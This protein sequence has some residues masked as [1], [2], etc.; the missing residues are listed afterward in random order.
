MLR[1][2]NFF[3]FRDSLTGNLN[4]YILLSYFRI[5]AQMSK[6]GHVNGR[7]A[8][9]AFQGLLSLSNSEP[10]AGTLKVMPLLR[11]PIAYILIRPFLSDVDV[12]QMPGCVPS[13]LFQ[14]SQKWHSDI[15]DEM[16]SIPRLYP[17][18][19]VWWHPDLVHSI[20]NKVEG[21]EANS[22]MCI[23]AA[24]DCQMNRVYL[25]KLR[26][27]FILGKT[28]PDFPESDSEIKF[29]DKANISDLTAVGRKSMGWEI[30][31]ELVTKQFNEK[32]E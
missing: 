32:C 24:P 11:E 26:H 13:K 14:I 6:T 5:E 23:S 8:F 28:P 9:R 7:S 20:E 12:N 15:Y 10:G 18:D 22:V 25:R 19:T 2:A 27:S 3:L 4:Q 29:E 31:E 21:N 30:E 16:V 17:G 1:Y